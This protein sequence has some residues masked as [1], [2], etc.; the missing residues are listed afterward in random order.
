MIVAIVLSAGL[1]TRF[2]GNKLLYRWWDKPVIQH[3]IENII[4][5]SVDKVVVV[6]GYMREEIEKIAKKYSPRVKTT[7]NPEYRLGMS[8]SVKHGVRYAI[9]EY[10]EA[11]EALVFVPGDCAWIPPV[12]Y[13]LVV[14][15][16][17]ES[18]KPVVVASYM[19]RRGHPIL[20]DSSVIPDIL[21]ISEETRGLKVVVK[22]YWW[23]TRVLET[24][25]PGVILDLDTY[26]DLNRVKYLI[27][28]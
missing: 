6:T 28:K 27:K 14:Q 16:F 7:Y 9:K 15:E 18:K 2:P 26:N 22:K 13:D 3:T 20:F 11:I 5:S 19:G 25:Y 21:S 17:R 24:N 4:G 8:T 10:G 12:I 23:D 1:S